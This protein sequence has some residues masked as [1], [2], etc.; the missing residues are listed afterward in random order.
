MVHKN[1]TQL[2]KALT[3]D[4]AHDYCTSNFKQIQEAS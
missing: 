1:K 3:V 2:V 4:E